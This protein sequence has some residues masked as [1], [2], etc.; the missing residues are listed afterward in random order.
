MQKITDETIDSIND[1]IQHMDEEQVEEI[2]NAFAKEQPALVGYVLGESRELKVPDARED[3]AYILT[4]IFLSFREEEPGISAVTEAEFEQAFN[5][6]FDEME[7]V[8]HE[9]FDETD[10][11]T[12][13]D[14]FSQPHLLQFAAAVIYGEGDEDEE[15]NFTEEEAGLFVVIFKTVISL[16]DGK[17]N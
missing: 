11:M 13:M 5:R 4:I 1:R 17:V 14:S 3:V 16:M 6:E 2:W 12:I 7:E 15:S 9:G 10:A 8:F